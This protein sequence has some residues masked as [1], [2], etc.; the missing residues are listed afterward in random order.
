MY[1]NP[2]VKLIEGVEVVCRNPVGFLTSFLYMTFIC[3]GIILFVAIL[4][5][6]TN[7]T[8]S[9]FRGRHYSVFDMYMSDPEGACMISINKDTG[10]VLSVKGSIAK[11]LIGKGYNMANIGDSIKR[12]CEYAYRAHGPEVSDVENNV[13][14]E[15]DDFVNGRL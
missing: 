11:Y 10:E 5:L 6:I 8:I 1:T 13:A 2:F 3:S 9:A 12:Y 14:R 7:K 15:Y 4:V